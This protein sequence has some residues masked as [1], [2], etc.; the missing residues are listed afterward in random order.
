ML[1]SGNIF[2]KRRVRVAVI[3]IGVE[4]RRRNSVHRVRADKFLNVHHIV[5]AGIFCAGAGPEN[6]LRLRALCRKLLPAIGAEDVLVAFIGLLA[7]S[8]RHL[9]QNTFQFFLFAPAGSSFETGNYTRVHQS[10]NAADEEACHTGHFA[11]VAAMS[12]ELLQTSDVGFRHFFVYL[13]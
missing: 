1:C 8:N 7:V 13:L 5:V 11:D 2:G 3:A 9:A 4:S 10:I 6:T 12:C